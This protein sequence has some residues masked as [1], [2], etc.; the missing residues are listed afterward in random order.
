MADKLSVL[1]SI[2]SDW[3]W[4]MDANLRFT[5]FSD[6][7]AEVFGVST[8][9][10][11]GKLRTDVPRTDYEDP[12]WRRHL[13]DL[14]NRRPFRDFE[15]SFVDARGR[16]RPVKISG[17]PLFGADGTFEGYIGVGHDL[18]E[19]REREQ[20]AVLEAHK[21]ESILQ[22]IDQGVVLLDRNLR[23]AAY[24]R[25]LVEWLELEGAGYGRGASYV[26]IVRRLAERGEFGTEEVEAAVAA[27]VAL[28][29]AGQRFEGER[30]R[31]D[32]RIL[33]V[34][35]NPLP[36]GGGVMTYSDVTE[37]RRREER[38]A[39]SEENFR[40]R[41]RNLPLPQWVYHRETLRFLEVNDPAIARYGY[42]HDEFLAMTIEDIRPPEE[43]PKLR[44]WLTPER[45][46]LFHTTEWRHLTRDGRTLE[47]EV[48][49]RDIDFEGAP[50]RIALIIDVT[51][52]KEAER[53]SQRLVETSQ[54]LIFITDSYGRF[55]LVGPSVGRLLGW[56]PEEMVGRSGAD[57]SHPD[58]LEAT[59]EVMR[60]SRR[61]HHVANFRARYLHKDGRAIP[62][63]WTGVWSHA[64][65]RHYFVGRDVSEI[66]RTE[67]Q[68]RQAQKMEAVGQLTGGVAH[69]FNNILMVIL[70]NV[71]ALREHPR[72]PDELGAQIE[73]I[74]RA[75]QRAADLTRQL[76]AFSRRQ[77]LRPRRTDVNALVAS[78]AGL[79]R[80]ALGEAIEIETDL[81]AGIW[82]IEVDRGQLQSALVNICINARDAMPDGGRLLIETRNVVLD[83]DY[84]LNHM[85]AA[86]GEHVMIALTDTGT[87]IAPEILDKVFE[88]FFTTKDV[89]QGT[90]LGLS[91]VY[92]F[93]RQSHG[94]VRI[95]SEPG[96]GTSIRIYLPR[97]SG[98][99]A[100]DEVVQRP[101]LP[102]G[103]ER[104]LVVEDD[105]QV[106]ETVA[107]Q[108]RSLG[109]DVSEA[110]DGAA[111][112]ALLDAAD[113]P[114]DLMLTDVVMPG[115]MNGRSLADEVA[116]RWPGTRLVFMSGY[117]ESAIVHHGRL[118]PGVV[119]LS[120]PFRRQ[121][122]AET[123]RRVLD[124]PRPR[125]G[126]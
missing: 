88:P 63:V 55:L 71:E 14:D 120:K 59:R 78:T 86:E 40:Y 30:R 54:D 26:D 41:F 81:T 112:L 97:N 44:E 53:L 98:R 70:A 96:H 56:T 9:A 105:P 8:T 25:R 24:N 109:Y 90:G 115:Q 47:V 31:R 10:L 5:F 61:G 91:M 29:R 7:F 99:E 101:A 93:V 23:V 19:L 119:L 89:G 16:S 2:A 17:M 1:A 48:Y 18:T 43:I 33:S 100:A 75:A 103:S 117:T 83:R 13:D 72:L 35:F 66:D 36:E 60:R 74:D 76:L 92:G 37:A 84:A 107:S 27:R 116:R 118:D 64:D 94:H 121:E 104:V 124:E 106:R 114:V 42:S 20:E 57:F 50:A 3:W 49:L 68:L 65:R 22:N 12:S 102:R 95:Y 79:M 67:A 110:S 73:G 6:R 122:L 125:V 77:A 39:R 11:V 15:T 85:D 126:A 4:E 28:V 113:R 38:L 69:D 62:F 51:A 111:A 108:V 21:L 123:L 87:G 32:G 45:L 58:D 52:R 46:P 34:V 82:S 80:R